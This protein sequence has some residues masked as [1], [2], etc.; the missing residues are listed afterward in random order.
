MKIKKKKS[1]KE[2]STYKDLEKILDKKL[3]DLTEEI[4][5]EKT[6]NKSETLER[7]L[8]QTDSILRSKKPFIELSTKMEAFVKD[9][10]VLARGGMPQSL[11]KANDKALGEDDDT[12]GG[13][14][15]PEEFN[16]EVIRYATESAIVRPRARVFPMARDI[17]TLPTLDQSSDKF[18]GVDLH[19]I[20]ESVL[21]VESQPKFGKIVLNSK[22]LIGL[23][24]TS[25]ELLADSAVN[26]ANF[27]VTL[28]GEAIAY[29]EDKQFLTGDGM[30]KP[31]GIIN[32]PGATCVVRTTAS[33]IQFAD[34]LAMYGDLPA[35][36]D[37][38]A[39]WMTT[40][41]GM[42]QLLQIRSGVWDGTNID[43]TAGSLLVMPN[44]TAGLPPTLLGKP[45]VLTD[46]LPA[47]GTK[48]DF[49]LG[50]LSS[51]FIGDRGALQVTSSI[52]DR[53]RYDE[54]VFRF[55][56]RVD[57]QCAVGSAFVVLDDPAS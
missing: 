48:G 46:K 36:A 54:T 27:L 22:K 25:D 4:K 35:W 34:I 37:P 55:V 56:K 26:L 21:K 31:L 57:G 20:G 2:N 45:I 13:F 42:E 52:H 30:G 50:D 10:K 7:S 19:W 43:E 15:V 33:K 5:R 41:A 53:F 17:L 3:G 24:P 29:E 51:Y 12:A 11:L 1:T 32:C 18:G 39:I 38:R 23:C 9:M 40:K 16:S 44:L 6:S 49:I 8:M 14:L 28:F 47:L